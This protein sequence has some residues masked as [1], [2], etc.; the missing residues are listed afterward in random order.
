MKRTEKKQT[1]ELEINPLKILSGK[2]ILIVEA[3]DRFGNN[4]RVETD[5]FTIVHVGVSAPQAPRNLSGKYVED[6]KIF[7]I[8]WDTPTHRLDNTALDILELHHYEVSKMDEPTQKNSKIYTVSVDTPTFFDITNRNRPTFYKVRAIDQEGSASLDSQTI[9]ADSEH[10]KIFMLDDQYS[11]VKVPKNLMNVLAQNAMDLK[12]ERKSAQEGGWVFKSM[13]MEVR[14]LSG[15][16]QNYVFG[17]PIEIS[18]G[19]ST[20]ERGKV[21][22]FAPN[23]ETN[24]AAPKPVFLADMPKAE[25]APNSFSPYWFNGMQW[26]KLG[27]KLDKTENGVTFNVQRV[28]AYQLRLVRPASAPQLNSIYPKTISPNGD[29]INDKVF[30]YFENPSD[31]PISGTIY[32]SRSVR[33]TDAKKIDLFLGATPALSWDGTDDNGATVRGGLYYYR[34]EIGDKTFTGAISVAK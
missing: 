2:W 24:A 33:V 3:Q 19:Y 17:E 13:N 22:A 20:D 12:I 9:A 11:Y 28:G 15:Q 18:F 6:S 10:S 32:D 1:D 34:I 5:T 31:A 7:C 14:D 26:I 8:H 25:N 23:F 29:S 4:S 30:F 21:F 16:A 27:S